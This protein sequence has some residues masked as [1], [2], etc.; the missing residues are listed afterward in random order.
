[1]K[2][3]DMEGERDVVQRNIVQR[4]MGHGGREGD[5]SIEIIDE[6]S[7]LQQAIVLTLGQPVNE[8][9][10]VKIMSWRVKCVHCVAWRSSDITCVNL[11]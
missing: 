5:G 6:F 2:T 3:V 11:W 8:R 7:H 9:S 1:M 4:E 10:E